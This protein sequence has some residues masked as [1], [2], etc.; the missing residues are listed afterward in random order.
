MQLPSAHIHH[1]FTDPLGLPAAG[2]EINRKTA[3]SKGG[4]G[5]IECCSCRKSDDLQSGT[6]FQG[7][8]SRIGQHKLLRLLQFIGGKGWLDPRPFFNLRDGPASQI[9]SSYNQRSEEHTSELQ[10][11]AYLVC[12]L[13]L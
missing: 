3:M 8:K 7:L 11:L 6:L 13:L 4:V 9:N 2:P 10:S 1:R 12:R 5:W